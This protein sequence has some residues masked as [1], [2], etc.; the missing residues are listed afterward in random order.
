MH[1]QSVCFL[2]LEFENPALLSNEPFLCS[3]RLWLWFTVFLANLWPI[4]IALVRDAKEI[5][6]V[7]SGQRHNTLQASYSICMREF[8]KLLSTAAI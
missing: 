7:L 4:Y 5:I 1:M 8:Y 6:I 3:V 2:H